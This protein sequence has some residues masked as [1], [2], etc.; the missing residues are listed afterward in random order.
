[1]SN[2]H[3][4][5]E[6][7]YDGRADDFNV[8]VRS[9][10]LDT[11]LGA[12]QLNQLQNFDPKGILSQMFDIIDE[13]SRHILRRRYGLEGLEAATLEAIGQELNLTRERIR[14]IEKESI[15]KLREHVRHHQLVAAHQLLT[16]VLNEH[17]SVMHEDD[18]V[19]TLLLSGRHPEQE[20]A[21]VFIL[22]LEESFEKLRHDDYHPSWYL[23]GFDL[24][25]LHEMIDEIVD[26]LDNHGQPLNE[27]DLLNKV[28]GREHFKSKQHFYNDKSLRNYLVISRKI[29]TNPFG[30]IGL[31]SWS[32]ISPRD[33]GDKAYLVMKHHGKPE[34]YA[35]ITDMINRSKFDNKVAYKETVHN[36]L[37]KDDRF[38][39]V[40]RGIYA[41][42]E[43]GFKPGVVAD[44][45]TEVLR[46]A[47]KP[48]TRDQIIEEVLKQRMVKKNTVLVG[49]SN[50]KRF[51]KVDRD[52]YTLAN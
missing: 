51:E 48:L 46:R 11:I 50:R 25:L 4:P 33:V 7:P 40:G 34:H 32:S 17:G 5:N 35:K 1:M 43:W 14:Q 24:S 15:R 6:Q 30:H 41:L 2:E 29:K 23:K 47:E 22:E 38:V 37:I 26:V 8:G 19:S 28:K 49:L 12:E 16:N 45:I 44:I 9:S 52:K 13:R 27:Q 3:T 21:V 18:L 36:E 31:S 42:S 20:A 39:L 10:I